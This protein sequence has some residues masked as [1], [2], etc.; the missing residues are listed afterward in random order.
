MK[1]AEDLQPFLAGPSEPARPFV[2]SWT[3]WDTAGTSRRHHD[4][5]WGPL[6]CI[7]PLLPGAAHE[8]EVWEEWDARFLVGKVR[9]ESTDPPNPGPHAKP[10]GCLNG[11]QEGEWPQDAFP[12]LGFSE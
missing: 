4:P 10:E 7:N 9:L 12:S 6:C 8:R 1:Q 3:T 5:L 11:H 2:G